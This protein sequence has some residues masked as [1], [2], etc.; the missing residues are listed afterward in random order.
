MYPLL[1]DSDY[2]LD[3]GACQHSNANSSYLFLSSMF[4]IVSTKVGAAFFCKNTYAS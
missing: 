2:Q 4:W 3:L 1:V